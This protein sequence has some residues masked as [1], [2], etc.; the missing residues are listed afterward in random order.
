MNDTPKAVLKKQFDIINE[1]SLEY[2]IQ[3]LFEMTELSRKIVSNR[4]RLQN[5]GFS[6]TELKIETFRVFY[7]QDFDDET[8]DHISDSMRRYLDI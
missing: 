3:S 2:R 8:L 1:K 5:P 4:I 7:K 6:E